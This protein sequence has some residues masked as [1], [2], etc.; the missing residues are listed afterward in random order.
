MD[1]ARGKVIKRR[2]GLALLA[3]LAIVAG[4]TG[5]AAFT[6]QV[7]NITARVEKDIALEPV[8]CEKPADQNVPC[9]VDPRGGDF[10][11]VLPQE[12]Y[13]K[14]IEVTLSNSFFEQ[15]RFFDLTFDLL[16]ECKQFSDGRNDIDNLEGIDNDLDGLIDEDPLNFFD[17]DGDG[18]VDEDPPGFPGS[19]VFP[20][21]REDGLDDSVCAVDLDNPLDGKADTVRHCDEEKLDGN[22][23]LHASVSSLLTPS[24][25]I[26]S[27][28]G[29]GSKTPQQMKVQVIGSGLLNKGTPKCRYEIELFAPPCIGGFNPFTD[30][31]PRTAEKKPVDCHLADKDRDGN[32]DLKNPQDFDEFFDIG[33]DFKIQVTFHSGF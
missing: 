9:F 10:G 32:P 2:L 22:L 3:A 18:L 6:A 20:D 31:H 8:I 5:L 23:R 1:K 27:P 12:S 21:C 4:V 14:I 25:C 7:V 26:D 28:L 19:D 13:V 29:P 16:W 11:V 17:D 33:D 24:R 15:E 30:P